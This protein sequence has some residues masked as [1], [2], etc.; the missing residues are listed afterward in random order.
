MEG[1]TLGLFFRDKAYGEALAK[2]LGLHYSNLILKIL[3][4]DELPFG[5]MCDVDIML[6]DLTS[7][8][9]KASAAVFESM[10]SEDIAK[11]KESEIIRRNIEG[12]CFW[13]FFYGEN[14]GINDILELEGKGR[15]SVYKYQRIENIMQNIYSAY[16]DSVGKTKGAQILRRSVNEIGV[17]DKILGFIGLEGGA[18][19]S[20][21]AYGTAKILADFYEKKVLFLSLPF[22][23]SEAYPDSHFISADD[24]KYTLRRYV[25]EIEKMYDGDADSN[26]VIQNNSEAREVARKALTYKGKEYI[27]A[28]NFKSEIPHERFVFK[29]ENG[30]YTFGYQKGI[31]HLKY[32]KADKIKAVIDR[33]VEVLDFE[34]VVIDGGSDFSP[35]QAEIFEDCKSL[36]FIHKGKYM[37]KRREKYIWFLKAG[38]MTPIGK[39][40]KIVTGTNKTDF[41][42]DDI[43]DVENE[44][45]YDVVNFF[46]C[47]QEK[48]N[49]K[50]IDII[51][52]NDID[53]IMGI[54]LYDFTNIIIK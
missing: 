34:F 42:K 21:I 39:Q 45:I 24:N 23:A 50:Y 7:A 10:E 4:Y 6:C 8:E 37:K 54:K 46:S 18:G 11:N 32:L 19:T 48:D 28:A 52:D 53:E 2:G 30:V 25:Y 40:K 3:D 38:R 16:V 41:V 35:F 17:L 51:N 47:G 33:L 22:F 29:D 43:F 14:H 27:P 12:E 49:V 9:I 31:N 26:D 20:S 1:I 13:V 44:R 15:L 36:I 5:E